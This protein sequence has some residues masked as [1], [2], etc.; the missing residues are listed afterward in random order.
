VFLPDVFPPFLYRETRK[1][2]R[3]HRFAKAHVKKQI[4]QRADDHDD[5]SLGFAS[6]KTKSLLLRAEA[7]HMDSLIEKCARNTCGFSW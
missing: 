1:K 7:G 3:R 5:G 4:R 6:S 2:P